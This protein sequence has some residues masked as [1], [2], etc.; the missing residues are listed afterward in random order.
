M[1]AGAVLLPSPLA[2]R[3]FDGGAQLG[4]DGGLGDVRLLGQ[5][6]G[7]DLLFGGVG[8]LGQ[9][10]HGIAD[11]F[12]PLGVLGQV[13]LIPQALE[14][15]IQRVAY[16]V[17]QGSEAVGTIALDVLVRVLC[18]GDLKHPHPHRAVPEQFQ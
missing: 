13:V 11:V 4:Q 16:A 14:P 6:P 2:A 12:E 8:A 9:Q 7:V 17:Q 15:E 3:F 18:A 10:V 5:P 1:Q